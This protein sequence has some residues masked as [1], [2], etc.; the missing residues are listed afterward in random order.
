MR[1][2]AALCCF[3][4]A[5]TASAQTND[6]VL[7]RN[8]SGTAANP[9]PG[10][11]RFRIAGNW[12]LFHDG[13]LFLTHSGQSGPKEQR[14]EVFSTNWLA[15]GAHR[16]L[17]DRGE[18][19]FRVRGSLEP[20]TIPEDGY[21]QLL[22]EISAESGGPQ[23]DTMRAHELIGEAA[24]HGA[25]RIG[26]SSYLH[27]YAAGVGDPPLGPVP[28]AQRSSSREF[29]EA[30]LA[31]DVQE[32]FHLATRVVTGGFS[33]R[34]F[35]LEGGVFHHSVTGGR[36]T[37]IDDG[38]IDSRAARVTLTPHP[39][40][41]IQYSRGELTDADR[42]VTSASASW[43]SERAAISVIRTQ[44]ENPAGQALVS[45]GI[46]LA[47]RVAKRNTFLAR[48]EAVDRLLHSLHPPDP[49]WTAHYSLGYIFDFI[50]RSHRAGFGVNIDYHTD[51]HAIEDVYGHKPQ[52]IF[53][54]LRARTD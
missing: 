49:D 9:G 3:L 47:L 41:S 20:L 14:N 25:L 2:A 35:S 42:E 19:L 4:I 29:A 40:L 28:F 21:P 15:F 8:A 53:L 10:D 39:N 34:F 27:L 5:A 23:I 51:T 33:T 1:R 11:A 18:L 6:L 17:G 16:T 13:S 30:P 7:L 24:V 31:Y 26:T 38:T 32:Q 22:Q 48:V 52:S 37:S 54:F 46:E 44:R 43:S 50:A 36:H 12:T 45:Q